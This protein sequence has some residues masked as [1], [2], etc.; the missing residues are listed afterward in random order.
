MSIHMILK[1]RAIR[2]VTRIVIRCASVLAVAAPAALAGQAGMITGIV[3]DSSGLPISGAEVA[4]A[5]TGASAVTGEKGEYRIAGLK[6][7]PAVVRARRLGFR[8]D[9][10][11]IQL[12]DAGAAGVIV[13]LRGVAVGLAPVVVRT[14]RVEYKGRLAGYYTR[15]DRR[16]SGNF[17][18]RA[19]IDRENPRTLGQLLQRAP[20]MKQYRG[21]GGLSGVRMRGR[22]CWP[23]VWLD[24]M[25]MPSGEFDL[26]GVS[27]G[28]LHGI[29]LYLGST[30]APM[31]YTGGRDFSSC[32]TILLW[33]RGP[34]T[35]PLPP[36]RTAAW[37]LQALV[38]SM[39]VYTADQV[40][41]PAVL[42]PARTFEVGYPPALFAEKREGKVVA[43]FVVD[44]NGRVESETFGIVSA[45]DA[46]FA[47]AVRSAIQYAAFKPALKDGRAVRQ[48]VHLPV[49]FTPAGQGAGA[50]SVEKKR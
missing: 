34:D 5:G 32:G 8:P 33:S 29:E 23:L 26:D 7:G 45:T 47:N 9:S 38:A 39:A 27:P 3:S 10:V 30:S 36:R 11:S 20:G 40:D 41:T 37:N 24:G 15:L 1:A 49:T 48:L 6:S 13:R 21:R 46:L 50:Q 42:D 17:I 28:S 4:I 14:S 2:I 44:S 18:T 31:Q 25:Q 12:G 35:D 43:E 16:L 22:N 19:E